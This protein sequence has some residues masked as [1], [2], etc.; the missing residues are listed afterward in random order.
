[1]KIRD[2]V[3]TLTLV[4][5]VGA[6]GLAFILWWLTVSMGKDADRLSDLSARTGKASE[7]YLTAQKFLERGGRDAVTAMNLLAHESSGL[8]G[9][10]EVMLTEAQ[11][12]LDE[13]KSMRELPKELRAKLQKTF[14]QFLEQS[15]EVGA[16]IE[17]IKD[18][19]GQGGL[20][21]YE[22]AASSFVEAT[23]ELE[24]WAESLDVK[25]KDNLRKEKQRVEDGR[26]KA[27][28]S[29]GG[30]FI[31]YL[32]VLGF[33]AWRIYRV[34]IAPISR[35]S[36]A[37][38]DA[39]EH[40]RP[41][42]K[43]SITQTPWAKPEGSKKKVGPKEIEVLS[44]RL[45]QLVNGLEETVAARTKELRAKHLALQ[46][47]TESL[48]GEIKARKEL[49]LELLHGQKMQA[50]GQLATGIA[51]EIRTPIQFVGDHL[52]FI[53]EAVDALLAPV[54]P[55]KDSREEKFIKENLPDAVESAK[56]G[57]E[58]ITEIV[59][60][61]KRFS[62]K[63]QQHLKQR[64]DLN[65]AV[66]DTVAISTNEWKDCAVLDTELD[67]DL[68]EVECLL[69]E[70]N[71]VLLNLIVNATHAIREFNNNG[72]LGKIMV[73]TIA[74]D[75]DQI[76]IEVEDDGGGIPS[77]ARSKVFEA[78]FT[79]KDMGVGSGQGLA[80]SHSV[81][82]RKHQGELTFDTETGKGTIFRIRLPLKAKDG[83][84]QQNH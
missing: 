68:P 84:D 19:K 43:D 13:L 72:E 69:G 2:Y 32:A 50:V 34:L 33:F 25:H 8:F 9:F 16:A 77:E 81:I 38:N 63:E 64:A 62:F 1:V 75:D 70:I 76:L 78:F 52:L 57:I 37:A 17:E 46:E 18:S 21:D 12:D 26:G 41:F 30:A 73:R 54:S 24:K 60:S 7:E 71:Q 59:A 83:E 65:Q 10:V 22:D 36:F 66:L 48:E 49:E 42:T 28:L 15:Q 29:M 56:M 23:K 20:D 53:D 39:I 6:F 35:M 58:R 44:R 31:L 3:L 5:F 47:R 67:P 11:K 40:S 45:W 4:G 80:I 55:E 82:V 27:Y 79:T 51:H 61:M 14:A 74:V